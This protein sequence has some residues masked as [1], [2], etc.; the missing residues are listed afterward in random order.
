[1]MS[2]AEARGFNRFPLIPLPRREATPL[3]LAPTVTGLQM[4]FPRGGAK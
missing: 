4:P 3:I 1:M 2:A